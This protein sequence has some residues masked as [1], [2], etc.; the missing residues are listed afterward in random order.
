MRLSESELNRLALGAGNRS[1]EAEGDSYSLPG[2]VQEAEAIAARLRAGDDVREDLVLSLK[3][4]IDSGTYQVSGTDIAE[5]M[6]R[7]T[8]ADHFAAR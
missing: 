6:V 8:L 5:M 1:A 4:R 7:R 3:E 2:M